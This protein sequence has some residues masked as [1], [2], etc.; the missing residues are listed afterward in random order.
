MQ[1]DLGLGHLARF[2]GTVVTCLLS[3]HSQVVAA[4]TQTLKVPQPPQPSLSWRNRARKRFCLP[5]CLASPPWALDA[6]LCPGGTSPSG[7]QTLGAS[8]AAVWE[9]ERNWMCCLGLASLGP[10]FVGDAEGVC[11]STHCRHWLCDLFSVRSSPV[12][13]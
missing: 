9:G 8:K 11:G 3:P 2:F 4:A 1:R 7:S 10:L 5:L 6:Q 12:H 13:R